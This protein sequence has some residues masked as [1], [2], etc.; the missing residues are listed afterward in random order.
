MISSARSVPWLPASRMRPQ[1]WEV[2][3]AKDFVERIE[4]KLAGK[5]IPGWRK[6][7]SKTDQYEADVLRVIDSIPRREAEWLNQQDQ[8]R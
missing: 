1:I 8:A 5:P 3:G 4:G 7:N 6:Y 2:T